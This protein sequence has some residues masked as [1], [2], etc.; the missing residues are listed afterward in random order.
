MTMSKG[1][2]AITVH[3]KVV[4]VGAPIRQP[5]DQ[6]WVAVKGEDDRP[7]FGE[8]GVEFDIGE[9]MRVL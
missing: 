2:F 5:V 1:V 3:V 9:T 8:D 4:M 6:S 7:I